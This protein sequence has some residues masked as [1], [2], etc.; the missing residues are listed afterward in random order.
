M[1]FL[2]TKQKNNLRTGVELASEIKATS[3]KLRKFITIIGYTY[4]GNK[5]YK[6]LNKILNP[7]LDDQI[8]FK[9]RC[10]E[11]N[12][13]DY[14]KGYDIVDDM[15]I[16]DVIIEDIKGFKLLEKELKKYIQDFSILQ[17]SWDCDNPI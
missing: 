15:L 5:K 9:I 3:S 6:S 11:I 2:E 8:Y 10:Y 13:E 12:K 14:Q 7:S 16:N 17:P 4:D 1:N